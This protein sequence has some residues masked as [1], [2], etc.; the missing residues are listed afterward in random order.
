VAAHDFFLECVNA[1][2]VKRH[3]IT[4]V[5]TEPLHDGIGHTFVSRDT[6]V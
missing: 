1:N 2:T 4:G 3:C 6:I 5:N